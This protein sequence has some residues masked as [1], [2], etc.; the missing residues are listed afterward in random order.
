MSG[1]DAQTEVRRMGERLLQK[2]KQMPQADTVE[3]ISFTIILIFIS[4]YRK[5][6]LLFVKCCSTYCTPVY[7]VWV[8]PHYGSLYEFT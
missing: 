3:I 6:P 2:L 7:T 8:S 1:Q 4:E 5:R